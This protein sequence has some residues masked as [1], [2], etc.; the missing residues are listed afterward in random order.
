M[1][2]KYYPISQLNY[3]LKSFCK[4]HQ[5]L[6]TGDNNEIV[7]LCLNNTVRYY[8]VFYLYSNY[9]CCEIVTI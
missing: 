1:T 4:K 2:I 5:Y 3:F 8:C 9:F 7:F 6:G